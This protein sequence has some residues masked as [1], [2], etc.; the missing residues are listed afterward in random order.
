MTT[1]TSGQS[2][3]IGV[4]AV[5][6]CG[7]SAVRNL[8]VTVV[9]TASVGGTLG[10]SATV[11]SGTNSTLFTLSGYTGTIQSWESSTDNFVSI[12]T[13]IGITTTTYTAANLTSTT[14]YRVVVKNG[15]SCAVNS[16]IGTVTVTPTLT[17]ASVLP[18]S[19]QSICANGSGTLLTITDTGGGAITH[20]WGKRA[21]S[22][23]TITNISGAT[24]ST[25]TP[26]GVDLT[27]GTWFVVCTSTPACGS[28]II[29]NEVQVVVNAIPAAPTVGPIV[30]PSCTVNIGSVLLTGLPVSGTLNPG[31]ITYSGTSYTVNG[32]SS[33]TYYYTV[34]N[35]TCSSLSSA[36]V[37]INA[38]TTNT[39]N[40]SSWSAGTPTTSQSLVFN[41]NYSLTGDIQGCSCQVNSGFTVTIPSGNTMT[42]TNAVTNGG[43]LIFENNASLIQL[44]DGAVNTG[45]IIY[46]RE[47]TPMKNFDYTYWSSPV[48]DQVLN[49]LSPNTLF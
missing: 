8:A 3:N 48:K 2:G 14:Q 34:S 5:N 9:A 36:A 37:S 24:G 17:A 20:Q 44:N 11:C 41:G 32:L 15:G 21:V 4:A 12:V 18:N 35:G 23:G 19:G 45:K 27:P 39:W 22:G 40:G 6:S 47:T 30:Q 28:S 42:I 29:S 25:Y 7:T 31:N 33:G 38:T 1:G 10:G 43:I 46:K 16:T 13:P 26:T 49:V